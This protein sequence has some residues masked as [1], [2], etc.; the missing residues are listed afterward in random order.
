MK[1]SPDLTRELFA[2]ACRQMRADQNT[3][4]R[5]SLKSVRERMAE[6]LL[7]LKDSYGVSVKG[8]GQK[9]DITLNRSDFASLA[10]TVLES[11]VRSLS[12]FRADGLIELKGRDVFIIRP[13]A[14]MRV[15]NG[16]LA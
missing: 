11:A 12:E 5:L 8:L 3:I 15:S 2:E 7:T 6:T 1:K 9:I 13:E 16:C 14:L 10:G 4:C